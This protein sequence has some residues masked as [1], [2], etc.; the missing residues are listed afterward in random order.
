MI[1]FVLQRYLPFIRRAAKE[2]HK[3]HAK[4]LVIDLSELK[5]GGVMASLMPEEIKKAT[6][7]QPFVGLLDRPGILDSD[8][9]FIIDDLPLDYSILDEIDYQYPTG[10]AYFT[11]MTKG[12]TRKCAFCAV[13]KLEPTYRAK[14]PTKDKFQQIKELYGEQQNLLLM[15]NNVLASPNFA[16]IIQEIKDM[17]FYKGAVF[18][19]PNQLDIAYRNLL[20]GINDKG[21]TLRIYRLLSAFIP[22]LK[23]DIANEFHAILLEHNLLKAGGVT[24]ENIIKAYAKIAPI[25]EMY[26]D[27]TPRKRFVDFNQGTDAR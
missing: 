19:E 22:R 17:G 1:E 3:R 24:K 13:P 21:Y 9:D 4:N 25:Y 2:D 20:A 16:E 23:G 12:C 15:D 18:V 10:S 6:G 14:I 26:R 7:I 27:K 8:N 5:V 11:Y